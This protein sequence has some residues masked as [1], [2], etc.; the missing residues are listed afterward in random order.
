MMAIINNHW[1]VRP[2]WLALREA[3]FTLDLYSS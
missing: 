3:V 1:R 2:K